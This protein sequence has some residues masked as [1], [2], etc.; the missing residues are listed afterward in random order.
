[1]DYFSDRELGKRSA[2]L[3]N[4]SI[5]AWNGIV[6]IFEKFASNN[7]FSGDFPE[8]CHDGQGISGFNRILFEDKIKAEI[9][10]LDVPINRKNEA[11][12]DYIS[13]DVETPKTSEEERQFTYA[14]LDFLEFCNFHMKEPI[15]GTFHSFF[16]HYHL[17]FKS[18]ESVKKSFVDEINRLF[19][20]NGIAY[21]IGEDGK[22]TRKIPFQFS[23][24]LRREFYTQD[25]RLNQLLKEACLHFFK[26]K[27]EDRIR[28][29]ERL[30]DAFERLKTYYSSNK[31]ISAS[32]LIELASNGNSK[33]EIYLQTE[34][35]DVLT[36][37]GNEF[38]IRHFE[39]DKIEVKDEKHIDY[40]FY[41]MFSLIDLLL[42]ELE[43]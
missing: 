17:T 5:P 10:D 38:Q 39:V 22:V 43:K 30:W 34:A 6:A 15:Q 31:K 26:P 37:I 14:I 13:F 24:L 9:P 11:K 3:E 42:K 23:E 40:L 33:L 28:S 36:K 32:Q 21:F 20:R 18:G 35:T 16:N 19:E 8:N 7:Y 4:I 27:F 1:M 2:T 25:E 29:L 12:T 41:R